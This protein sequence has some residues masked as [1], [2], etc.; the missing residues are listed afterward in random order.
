MS[1][2]SKKSLKV[3]YFKGIFPNCSKTSVIIPLLMLCIG[4]IIIILMWPLLKVDNHNDS[5]I[6]IITIYNMNNGRNSNKD[7]IEIINNNNQSHVT[8]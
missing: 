5:S 4:T 6:L 8:V 1:A 3:L 7:T 2:K